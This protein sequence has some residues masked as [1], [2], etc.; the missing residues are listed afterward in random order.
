MRNSRH[1]GLNKRDRRRFA[2]LQILGCICCT[3]EGRIR[4]AEIHHLVEGRKRL[5]HQATIP[6]CP[7]HHRALP[8]LDGMDEAT[9]EKLL[10]PSL[11]R[12]KREFIARYGT[13]HDLLDEINSWLSEGARLGSRD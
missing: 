5:G 13:E 4:E 6:L 9:S 2:D 8:P 3:K 12:N 10:G 7:W 11:A 1:T